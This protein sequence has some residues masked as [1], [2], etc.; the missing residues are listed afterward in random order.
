M[1]SFNENS[2]SHA[3][4]DDIVI[5]NA[6]RNPKVFEG[7]RDYPPYYGYT[8][9]AEKKTKLTTISNKKNITPMSFINDILLIYNSLNINSDIKPHVAYVDDNS[10]T[11]YW[12][13]SEKIIRLVK[14]CSASSYSKCKDF[15][16]VVSEFTKALLD[17][18]GN[19]CLPL[20]LPRE[21]ALQRIIGDELMELLKSILD[22]ENIHYTTEI[23]QKKSNGNALERAARIAGGDL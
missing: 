4:I 7:A 19:I 18:K 9:I 8:S 15:S 1:I 20:P 11:T 16:D 22:E 6:H 10:K 5:E 21:T 12:Y 13:T 14:A 17:T 3:I 23:V 2:Y